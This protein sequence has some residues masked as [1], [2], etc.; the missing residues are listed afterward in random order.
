MHKFL[1]FL[2]LIVAAAPAAQQPQP[3][4]AAFEQE[5]SAAKAAMASGNYKAA[6]DGFKKANKLHNNRCDECYLQ[7]AVVNFKTGFFEAAVQNCDRA[8]SSSTSDAMK[9]S[10]HNLKGTAYLA[11]GNNGKKV[12]EA[13]ENELRMATQLA[14]DSAT[15]HYNLATALLRESKGE[16]ARAEL[17]AALSLHPSP[18]LEKRLNAVLAD[19]RRATENFAPDFHVTT[20]QGQE[21]SLEQLAGKIVVIDFWATWCGPCV[22]SVPEIRA[23]TRKYPSSKLAVISIS[24]D[25]NDKTWREFIANKKMDW[26]QVRDSNHRLMDTFNVEVIPTYLV[27]DGSGIVKERLTGSDDQ[28]SLSHRLKSVLEKM[29]ELKATGPG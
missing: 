17:N 3:A 8:I 21:L 20:M 25:E 15:F 10:A 2:S 29:P 24:G 26:N 22:Q 7:S 6:L 27:I 19:P 16:A 13:A 9:A 14:N 12:L 11:S 28:E 4:D 23:L 18:A 1:I 5:F